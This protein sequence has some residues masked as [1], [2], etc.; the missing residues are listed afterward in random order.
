VAVLHANPQFTADMAAARAEI[1]A[2]RGNGVEAQACA[3]EATA[4]AV[5]IPGVE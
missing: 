1:D 5:R 2:L 3:A 4:L